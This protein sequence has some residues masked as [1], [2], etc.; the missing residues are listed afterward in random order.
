MKI[1]KEHIKLFSTTLASVKHIIH[2]DDLNLRKKSQQIMKHLKD[3]L[4]KMSSHDASRI[5]AALPAAVDDISASHSNISKSQ[6][7]FFFEFF[8]NNFNKTKI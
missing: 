6:K 7:Y 2:D 3:T 8:F 5:E 1:M 4:G